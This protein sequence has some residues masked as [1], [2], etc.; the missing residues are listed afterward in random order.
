MHLVFSSHV[1][2]SKAEKFRVHILQ[3]FESVIGS[4]VTIE[5][6]CE[7]RKDSRAGSIIFPASHDGLS[8][9]DAT[10]D[11]VNRR[12]RK[13][14]EGAST[15]FDST[16][17]GKSEIVE[18]ETSPKEVKHEG[19]IHET[20]PD[21][22]SFGNDYIG[23]ASSIAKNSNVPSVSD[24]RKLGNGNPNLSLM[25]RKVSLAH[26]LQRAEGCGQQSGW[27]QRK[28]VSIAE[29]LEQEN[30]YVLF[31]IITYF[32][33]VTSVYLSRVVK[34][35]C[36]PCVQNVM[37]AKNIMLCIVNV[38]SSILSIVHFSTI[39]HKKTNI[40]CSAG[41]WNQDLEACFAG[42]L[43]EYHVER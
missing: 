39:E 5:I 1:T 9:M 19:H 18:L 35:A 30:L 16:R 21:R 13:E 28:A 22:R 33:F 17:I 27:S 26:V 14:R 31:L 37:L 24:V 23:E 10:N 2:K 34:C 41:D 40:F 29:K 4:P 3:A 15:E 25:R 32:Y 43:Q 8:G 11:D 36:A 6:R 7:S 12:P 20:Q 42:R 38:I